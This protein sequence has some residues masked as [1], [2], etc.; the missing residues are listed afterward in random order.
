M[1]SHPK[2]SYELPLLFSQ[3]YAH[4]YICVC[5]YNLANMWKSPIK[6]CVGCNFDALSSRNS[7]VYL[8]FF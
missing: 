2:A 5:T 4:I 3:T 6:F 1:H 7:Y 8:L